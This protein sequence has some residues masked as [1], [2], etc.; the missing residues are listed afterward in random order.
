MREPVTQ[1]LQLNIGEQRGQLAVHIWMPE[2][3][4]GTL[5]CVHPL[6][7]NGRDFD[8]L[9]ASLSARGFRVICPDMPGHG[10]SSYFGR[11]ELYSH[12]VF[13]GC[14][15]AVVQRYRG[16]R[17]HF[18]GSSWGASVNLSLLAAGEPRDLPPECRIHSAIVN[19]LGLEWTEVMRGGRGFML[20]QAQKIYAD[21]ESAW[22][23]YVAQRREHFRQSEF[24]RIEPE[25]AKAFFH[26]RI[27]ETPEGLRYAFDVAIAQHM[28]PP[29]P[30]SYPNM[31]RL[32][33]SL[34]LPLFFLYG[35]HSALKNSKAREEIEAT[36]P[37]ARFRDDLDAGH[38][39]KLMTPEQ[40]E[41]VAGFLEETNRP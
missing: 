4:R 22:Q 40:V 15:A 24:D 14:L 29:E 39:P 37:H 17:I 3:P 28:P 18:L 36:C 32:M 26:N 31:P 10:R 33:R 11:E 9:G 16:R 20:D 25:V 35:R 19:D 27:M 2:R 38:A 34:K 12:A 30:G 6:S 1:T 8:Y 23:D 5:Y 7:G 41:I 21:R 13:V